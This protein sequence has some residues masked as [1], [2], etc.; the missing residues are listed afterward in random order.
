MDLKSFFDVSLP[1]DEA[2]EIL[3]VED[4]PTQ[5]A[6]LQYIL[7]EHGFKVQVTR[8]GKEALEKLK[9][10]GFTMV[11][12]DVVMPEMDGYELCTRIKS[13][14][15]LKD[16]PVI[17]LTAL[18][19]PSDIIRGLESG[20]DNFITK[21]YQERFLVSRIQYILINRELRSKAATE[22]GIEIFFA[23]KRHFLAA[24]RIQIIDLLLSSYEAAVE[25][26]REL[27][28]A[29]WE[30]SKAR[31]T[32]EA[33]AHKLR[34]LIEAMDEGV[35]FA[36]SNDIITEA[37]GWILTNTGLRREDVVGKT[38]WDLFTQ[39]ELSDR[40]KSG[41]SDFKAGV[42][43]NPLVMTLE[44]FGKDVSFRVQPIFD[45]RNYKGA[46][47]NIVDV[48]DLVDA[49]KKMEQA[50]RAKS[51]FL[52]T[53]SHEIRTPM[54]G[55]IGMTE[56][57]LQTDL[58]QEQREYLLAVKESGNAL[59]TL[60]NDILDVSKIE[61]G[62]LEL[63][64]IEFRLRDFL[65][66]ALSTLVVQAQSRGLQ[67]WLE[68]SP[69]VPDL[70]VGDPGLLRQVLFNLIGNA[71]KFTEKGG[72]SITVQLDSE[73]SEEATFHFLVSDTG[74][75]IP[76]EQTTKIF[77]RFEQVDG[78]DTR[79]YGGTG[80]GL[81][82]S[83]QLVRMM[84][85]KVWVESGVGVGSKFHFTVRLGT[86]REDSLARAPIDKDSLRDLPVLIV[87]DNATNRLILENMLLREGLKTT[88]VAGG[89]EAL[90]ALQSASRSDQPFAV[91]ITDQV[92]PEMDGFTLAQK[93]RESP[94]LDDVRVIM[95]A[96]LGQRGD[97]VRCTQAGIAGYLLKPIEEADLFEVISRTLRQPMTSENQV[98][99]I[100][101][102]SVRE[103]KRNLRILLVED[104]KINQVLATKL[105]EK[106]GH[107]SSVA[108]NGK[109]ALSTLEREKFDLVLMDVQM[110]EMD[111]I[112]ATRMIRE[113]EKETGNH[114]PIVAMTAY[115]MDSDRVRCLE[116]GMDAY[117]SKPINVQELFKTVES[118]V[119]EKTVTRWTA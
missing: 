112:Q 100:T 14:E 99:L 119:T 74:I 93:I 55:I 117:V 28:N 106:W 98:S 60:I 67:L 66:Q 16:T 118:L 10:H 49:R 19:D 38:L 91:V 103:S 1:P 81:A 92:M 102:H 85:G 62:K 114:I 40:L 113:K 64:I 83:N 105:L 31:E 68:V 8:N 35:V 63:A 57:A 3:V 42:T 33:E 50:S 101:R 109:E 52:A 36:D 12:S 82:I 115:A 94:G 78:S 108:S 30:L 5:A 9:S 89:R 96:S 23:G 6:R 2:H 86:V 45:I 11:I 46:I 39:D 51:E 97:A 90:A 111:G 58:S 37:N 77:E 71:I 70:I 116:A 41:V 26:F 54:N 110:P 84:G 76:P 17:L 61:A 32:A 73:D 27:E 48:T 79:K 24:D 22:M 53:M 59:L 107:S 25:Q 75:G 29:N 13:D 87:D 104:N 69:D 34:T 18:S 80:L 7:E 95:L 88:A 21:P 20:A 72:V 43:K 15:H 4:S 44:I 56:I 47:L 65:S